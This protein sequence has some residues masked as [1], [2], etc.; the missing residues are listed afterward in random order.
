MIYMKNGSQYPERVRYYKCFEYMFVF[1]KGK[2]KTI[3]LICDRQNKWA[4][5]W[6]KRS[7]RKKDGTLEQKEK[8]PYK[9]FGI[10][11]NVWKINCG[12][13]FTTKDKEAYMHPAMFPEKLAGDHILSWSKEGDIVLDPF[14]GS[15]TTTKMAK[16]Y[17]RHYIGIDISKEYCELARRRTENIDRLLGK[18]A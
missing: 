12:F 7:L 10:R 11:Y 14:V 15:G 8:V 13:G 5:S 9:A 16:L 18:K 1:S 2:P 17:N 3:N 6:G 4:G